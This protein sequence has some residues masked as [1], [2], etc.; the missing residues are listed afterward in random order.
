MMTYSLAANSLPPDDIKMWED[1]NSGNHVI[2]VPPCFDSN[3]VLVADLLSKSQLCTQPLIIWLDTTT[4]RALAKPTIV[5]RVG[6]DDLPI[7]I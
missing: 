7:S 2:G 1:S 6:L 4:D 5:I 3:H